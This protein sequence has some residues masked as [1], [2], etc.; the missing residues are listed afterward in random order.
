MKA[1]NFKALAV[2]SVAGAAFPA[3]AQDSVSTS[4]GLPGDGVSPYSTTE[5]INSYRVGTVPFM[6]SAGAEFAIAPLIKSSKTS[7]QFYGSL[8][9]AQSISSTLIT[10]VPYFSGDYAT[11]S[12]AGFGINP[13][14][15][16][17]PNTT[18][19]DGDSNQFG[20]GFAEFATTDAGASYNAVLGAIVNYAS[21]DPT[22]LFV[23]RLGGATNGASGSENSAQF[24]FGTV[25]ASGN[26]N[27][28]SDDFGATGPNPISGNNYFRVSMADRDGS[29]VNAISNAGGA[30]SAATDDVLRGAGTAHL[31][32]N[33]IPETLAGRSVMLGLNFNAQ[34]VY[35]SAANTTTA[36]AAHRA[37]DSTGDSAGDQRGSAGFYRAPLFGDDMDAVGTAGIL[38]R[39]AS[40]RQDRL[41]LW[42]MDQNGGVLQNETLVLPDG[43]ITDS[44]D[45]FTTQGIDWAFDHYHSQVA[46][47]GGNSQV[48]LGRDLQGRSLVGAVAYNTFFDGSVQSPCNGLF[49]ARFD[50]DMPSTPEWSLAAWWDC[51]TGN[52]KS[53]VDES[54]NEIGQIASFI[55]TE[56]GEVDNTF[57]SAGF[58]AAGNVY[59][60][61]FIRLFGE[62]GMEGTDDDD[63][64]LA[65]LR[66][67]YD[68][69]NF[70]W[71]LERVVGSGDVF[72][73]E[74]TGL[75]YQIGFIALNDGNSISSGVFWSQNVMQDA[76]NGAST[77]D[78]GQNDP[79]ALGG[80]VFS[81]EIVYD[82]DQDGDFID[83]T[84]AFGMTEDPNSLDEAYNT[85]LWV[86]PAEA[87]VAPECPFDFNGDGMVGSS[88]LA[89]LLGDWDN[90]NM[91][92][93]QLANLLGSW[94]PCPE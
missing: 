54:G 89:T 46:F 75:E 70:C 8:I 26:L 62:D 31:T 93:S 12:E 1:I 48:A 61:S 94:G 20:V 41:R 28:R 30:D 64:D 83:P 87:G 24:G 84:S 4:G 57:S 22:T 69:A 16:D 10:G 37:A 80:L 6:T 17:T 7:S 49:V 29:T 88:D 47:R 9:S 65:L 5:Q 11:W 72:V 39:N 2:I 67:V 71:T 18:T 77:S 58:D 74:G 27:F 92:S 35:E 45:D 91:P 19:P 44:C 63:F 86:G 68:P 23:T 53:V 13:D 32:P 73:S 3:F 50:P 40:G 52:G 79:L 38:G 81:A 34:Y 90:L 60:L 15:N 36:T 51:Q 85:I 43:D 21:T 55:E 25:D 66:G 56:G 82:Y 33:C 76:F 78:L 42:T 59:F 14:Q